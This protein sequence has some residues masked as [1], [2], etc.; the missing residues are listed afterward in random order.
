MGDVAFGGLGEGPGLINF[1]D[2][3]TPIDEMLQ[4]GVALYRQ[5]RAAADAMFRAALASDPT[6]LP[7]YLCLAK[8]HAYS[9]GLDAALAAALAG[10]AE[11]ARQ[12]GVTA[13]FRQWRRADAAGGDDPGGPARFAL[14]MIKALAFVHLRRG[15]T[16]ETGAV[17]GE[18]ARLGWLEA[19]GGHVVAQLAGLTDA[20]A[21]P[22]AG[23]R[24]P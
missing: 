17:L 21:A 19:V 16:V 15:E 9:G 6:V 18:L 5:D 10:I 14:Y 23:G 24:Q 7:T 2:L 1:G 12:M 8:I 11:A 20:P 13:D 3:P 4:S 22:D